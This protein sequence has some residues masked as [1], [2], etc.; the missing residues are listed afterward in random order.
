MAAKPPRCMGSAGNVLSVLMSISAPLATM[1]TVTT[2]DT[3]SNALRRQ[4]LPGIMHETL[5]HKAQVSLS[6]F[7][8]SNLV[9][10]I[11]LFDACSNCC[12]ILGCCMVAP[13]LSVAK[14]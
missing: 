7:V 6:L 10:C 14:S 4:I 9:F 1:V 5:S 8:P 11:I 2:S 12:N 3:P 13:C